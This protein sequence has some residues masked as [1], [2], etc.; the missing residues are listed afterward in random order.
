M[1]SVPDHSGKLLDQRAADGD[2]GLT[3]TPTRKR[4]DKRRGDSRS[5]S[6]PRRLERK[7]RPAL[8]P[9]SDQ[10]QQEDLQ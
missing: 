4:D 1:T 8:P 9:Q 2:K 10:H 6:R 5:A 7:P 3:H